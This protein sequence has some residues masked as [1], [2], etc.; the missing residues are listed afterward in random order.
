MEY[1]D[2]AIELNPDNEL[3]YHNKANARAL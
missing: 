3:V 2:K 1:Y